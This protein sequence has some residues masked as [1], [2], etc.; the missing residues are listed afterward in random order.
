MLVGA[1]LYN[2]ELGEVMA[3]VE[4]F[5]S[6]FYV[7]AWTREL[8]FLLW[9]VFLLGASVL[10]WRPFCQYLCPLG[11]ALAIPGSLRFS[12]PRR[13]NF[14]TSCKICTRGCEP[15]A[16]DSKGKI[17]PRDCLSCMECEANYRDD[18]VCPPLIGIERLVQKGA[19]RSEADDKKLRRLREDAKSC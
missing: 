2:A 1:F 13:R 6:T 4:P 11:A 8:G 12:G 15:R 3:E 17:D 18:A 9:W 19:E 14:C 16:I 5:K 10:V 7:F